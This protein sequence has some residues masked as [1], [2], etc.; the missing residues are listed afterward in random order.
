MVSDIVRCAAGSCRGANGLDRASAGAVEFDDDYEAAFFM[1]VTFENQC[2]IVK[3]LGKACEDHGVSI[4]RCTTDLLLAIVGF[5]VCFTTHTYNF[6]VSAYFKYAV[7]QG[8]LSNSIIF[9][10]VLGFAF[11]FCS[12]QQLPKLDSF[13]VLTEKVKAS[14]MEAVAKELG[15]K[16]WAKQVPFWMP[17]ASEPDPSR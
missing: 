14:A 1:R 4:F 5:I 16:S 6:S 11:P 12:M 2:G 17:C 8:F 7:R 15:A 13:V 10:C 3:D 9:F